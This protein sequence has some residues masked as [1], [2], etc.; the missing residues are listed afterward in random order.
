MRCSLA[1]N[2]ALLAL[3]VDLPQEQRAPLLPKLEAALKAHGK[4]DEM[5]EEYFRDE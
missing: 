3:A 1:T 5:W 2:A 4:F